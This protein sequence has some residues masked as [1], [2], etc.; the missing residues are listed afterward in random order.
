MRYK[1]DIDEQVLQEI[2]KILDIRPSYGYKRITALINKERLTKGL[3]TYNKKRIYRVMEMNGLLLKKITTFRNARKKTGKI[4][5]LHSDTRWCSDGL[6]IQCF[7][8]EKV[9]V[10]FSLDCHDRE[11]LSYV[12]SKTPLLATDI[13]NLMIDSVCKRFNSERTPRQIQ[14]LSDRGA[15]YRA[16]ETIATARRLGLKSCFTAPYSPSSNGMSEAF[17]N[18]IK[19]DYVYNSDC[20][21]AD[22]VLEL[23][24]EWFKDYNQEAPH[25]GLGMKSP[26][27]YRK[28]IILGV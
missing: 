8:G 26:V 11:A 3:P 13:Q 4:I 6:E 23:L 18:T 21:S 24:P 12:A 25:S 14:W 9:Y 7:D 27:E 5:T 17:V 10:A 16:L 20:V 22:R 1:K 19:R 15:I 2:K 28:S